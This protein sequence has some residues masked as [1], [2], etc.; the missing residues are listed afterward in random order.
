MDEKVNTFDDLCKYTENKPIQYAFDNDM[1]SK[2]MNKVNGIIFNQMNVKSIEMYVSFANIEIDLNIFKDDT[3]GY[4]ECGTSG[5]V[6]FK[7]LISA[8]LYYSKLNVILNTN[9]AD[10]FIHFMTEIYHSFLD[11]Y[12]HFVTRHQHQLEVIHRSLVENK[13]FGHCDIMKCQFT[14]KHYGD[15][16]VKIKDPIFA[17]YRKTMDSLH[18]YLFHLYDCGLRIATSDIKTE[19]NANES[20][21]QK[22]SRI[23][24]IISQRKKI[25][26]SFDRIT[27]NTKF[28]MEVTPSKEDNITLLD[29]LYDVLCVECPNE[30]KVMSQLIEY[31]AA[32]EY[33]SDALTTDVEST[34]SGNIFVR[35]RHCDVFNTISHFIHAT[36]IRS[37][38]FQIGYTF[39]YWKHYASMETFDGSH[40]YNDNDHGGHLI[41]ALCIQRKYKTFKMEISEYTFIDMRMYHDIILPK[42]K[43]YL[44]TIKV[45][46]PFAFCS[47][48]SM[49]SGAE[50]IQ[51]HFDGTENT[52]SLS[53][54]HLLAL[55]L[56]C[57]FTDL[58]RDFS[59][60]FRAVQNYEPLSSIKTR[61]SIY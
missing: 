15:N 20:Y 61:N 5:C 14:V 49:G 30:W 45:K 40:T 47:S 12:S 17:F 43:L 55:I 18:F 2:L 3:V 28:T 24:G 7:R 29:V 6:A 52:G 42:A 46:N 34:S 57:D 9:H 36:Q 4:D 44:D 11:D 25:F 31:I 33:D 56:Y 39:Y 22:F 1:K 27:K 32:E 23:C 21:D 53:Y 59:S 37:T 13:R 19:E 41:S 38:S 51:L 10:I 60:T 35:I 16:K 50:L 58:S 8:L 54:Y 48:R 26:S